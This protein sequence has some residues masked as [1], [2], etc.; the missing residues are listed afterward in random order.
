MNFKTK[1]TLKQMHYMRGYLDANLDMLQNDFIIS[2]DEVQDIIKDTL[3]TLEKITKINPY[4]YMIYSYEYISRADRFHTIKSILN[5]II[6][7]M[8]L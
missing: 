8:K 1:N 2:D 7:S 6:W 5:V 4:K 3:H